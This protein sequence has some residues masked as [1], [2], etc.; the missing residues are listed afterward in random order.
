MRGAIAAGHLL[1][2][3]A[4][5]RVLA[6]GGSAVDACIAAAF[7]SWVSESP[8][9]GPGGGGFFLV[10]DAGSGRTRLADFFVCE[11][12]LGRGRRAVASMEQVDVA[13]QPD[14]CLLY[15]SPS[16]TRLGMISYAVFCLK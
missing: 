5:A 3:E 12:G 8:L 15:T 13:F 6:E 11:P 2:A 1:T 7:A 14:S 9:T 4:G 16:P 10:H